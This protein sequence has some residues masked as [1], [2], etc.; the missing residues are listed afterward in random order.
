MSATAE[1]EKFARY[2]SFPVRGTLEPAP[3]FS[4]EG[5]AFKISEY[6]LDDLK[7]LGPVSCPIHSN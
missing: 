4:V 3:I 1:S 6:Y 5:R 2:F 7:P